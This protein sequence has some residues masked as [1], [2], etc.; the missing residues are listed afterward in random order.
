MT[1]KGTIDTIGKHTINVRT[2]VGDSKRL[3]VVVTITASGHQIA[4]KEIT[5]LP[6]GAFYCVNEKAWFTEAV[7]L[8]WVKVVLVP[9][10]AKAPLGIVPLLLLDQ[11]K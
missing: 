3:T 4:K 1:Q 10:A 11:F 5:T 8:D 9:W 2:S 6:D 7:M